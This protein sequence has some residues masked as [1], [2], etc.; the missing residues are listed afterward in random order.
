MS[1]EYDMLIRKIDD[2][3]SVVDSNKMINDENTLEDTK[4]IQ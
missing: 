2:R 1:F 3:F 4:E